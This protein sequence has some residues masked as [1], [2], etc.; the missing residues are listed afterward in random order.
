MYD[1]VPCHSVWTAIDRVGF[2]RIQSLRNQLLDGFRV[3]E[4]ASLAGNVSCSSSSSRW[5][6]QCQSNL[7]GVGLVAA[8]LFRAAVLSD[9]CNRLGEV[10][11]GKGVRAGPGW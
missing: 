8:A 4:R 3:T 1:S 9:A 7:S 10:F 6:I 5:S 11:M 2:G